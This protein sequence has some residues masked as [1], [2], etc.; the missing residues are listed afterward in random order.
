M[1]LFGQQG[2]RVCFVFLLVWLALFFLSVF[3]CS[4]IYFGSTHIEAAVD[5]SGDSRRPPRQ[6]E[7]DAE[8]A[9]DHVRVE[10][11]FENDFQKKIDLAHWLGL[12]FSRA[13]RLQKLVFFVAA[14]YVSLHH[15]ETDRIQ[16]AQR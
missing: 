12:L 1:D 2:Q 14:L 10:E 6:V 8:Q 3:R 16:E 13:D 4:V 5:R 7:G 11:S 9:N 15:V